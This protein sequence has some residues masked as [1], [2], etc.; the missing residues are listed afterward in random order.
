MAGVLSDS[1]RRRQDMHCLSPSNRRYSI[2]AGSWTC[3]RCRSQRRQQA[4]EIFYIALYYCREPG[5]LHRW[6]G[7]AAALRV[8]KNI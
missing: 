6:S 8:V 7:D 1:S 5:W 3:K 4:N 2:S